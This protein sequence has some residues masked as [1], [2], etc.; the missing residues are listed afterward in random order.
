LVKSLATGHRERVAA[1]LARK[2]IMRTNSAK[3]I[4][5]ASSAGIAL[6]F[7][8]GGINPCLL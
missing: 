4:N 5:V 8:A 7:A 3:G 2:A 1:P 6:V